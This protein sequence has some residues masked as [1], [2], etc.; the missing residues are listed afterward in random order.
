[1]MKKILALISFV[2]FL[3]ACGSDEKDLVLVP[4]S[5]KLNVDELFISKDG[6]PVQLAAIIKP[7][8]VPAEGVWTTSDMTIASVSED[9]IV[10]PMRYGKALITFTMSS[11][12]Q[13][14][15]C[16]VNIQD[17]VLDITS[18]ELSKDFLSLNV[19]DTRGISA[20]II[21]KRAENKCLLWGSDDDSIASVNEE[22][23][24]SAN[25]VGATFIYIKTVNNIVSK[26]KVSVS[27]AAS[28][29]PKDLCGIYSASKLDSISIDKGEV[30]SQEQMISNGSLTKEKLK[31]YLNAYSLK[32]YSN[33]EVNVIYHQYSDYYNKGIIVKTNLENIYKI[34]INTDCLY[35]GDGKIS[36]WT[37]NSDLNEL[38]L[39]Y[40]KGM[41][42]VFEKTYKSN[43][44]RKYFNKDE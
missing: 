2:I 15:S 27:D 44:I 30:F 21:P 7:I 8:S 19:G 37:I 28:C 24:I 10:S 23:I 5:L 43:I 20:T 41:I 14:A 33:G 25:K 22:G 32:I 1:M 4:D 31:D 38:D 34:Y 3:F 29:L 9:G 26:C 16:I 18:V 35:L 39:I 13:Q 42:Q 40:Y 12:R 36:S 6:K 17:K 11:N